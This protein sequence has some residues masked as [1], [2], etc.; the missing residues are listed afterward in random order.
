MWDN[1]FKCQ[2]MLRI[3]VMELIIEVLRTKNDAL[4]N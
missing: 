2:L 4:G 3:F 1:P